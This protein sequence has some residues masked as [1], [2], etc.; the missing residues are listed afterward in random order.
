MR[1][2]LHELRRIV[3]NV[4]GEAKGIKDP[5]GNIL[6]STTKNLD[7]SI[8]CW[9]VFDDGSYLPCPQGHAYSTDLVDMSELGIVYDDELEKLLTKVNAIKIEQDSKSIM[10][11]VR[12]LDEDNWSRINS[13]AVAMNIPG[14]RVAQV[15]EMTNDT[16]VSTINDVFDNSVGSYKRSFKEGYV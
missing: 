13:F 5:N 14:T 4:L 12:R 3:R 8:P 10:F 11:M 9:Y 2:Y 6:P 15:Y 7:Q 16:Y 1:I